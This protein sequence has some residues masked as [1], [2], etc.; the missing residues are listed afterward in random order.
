MSTRVLHEYSMNIP[1]RASGLIKQSLT[2]CAHSLQLCAQEDGFHQAKQEH[3][4]ISER[5]DYTSKQ[6]N[7]RQYTQRL[8]PGY[9]TRQARALARERSGGRCECDGI[10]S[11]DHTG[12]CL[13]VDGRQ[14]AYSRHLVRLR[15]VDGR[16]LCPGCCSRP[17][18]TPRRL[19]LGGSANVGCAQ[20]RAHE[21]TR[22]RDDCGDSRGHPQSLRARLPGPA[23]TQDTD[24]LS[25]ALRHFATAVWPSGRDDT[26]AADVCRVPERGEARP[27]RACASA[28]GAVGAFTIA[29]RRWF[30]I[31]TN[32]LRDVERPKSRPRDRL[33]S[34][35]EFAACKALAPH[36][37]RLAMQLALLTGQ[38][39]GD[40]IRFRWADI[41]EV[42]VDGRTFHE[43]QIQQSKTGKRMAIEITPE[44]EAV[45]D[46]CWQLKGGG[47]QGSEYV[48]PTKFGRPFTSAG[49][50]ATWQRVRLKW[51]RSGGENLRFHDIR[52]LAA[53]KCP[54]LEAAQQLLGHSNPAMTRRV[55]RRGIERVK[56]LRLTT[57]HA[58]AT[59]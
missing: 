58:S 18:S 42:T 19:P 51:E 25:T 37:V 16:E 52:A 46:Q 4:S 29:V 2:G 47:S 34:D 56:P 55:Y 11:R 7:T 35:E 24:G 33:I 50:R 21:H 20:M 44:L 6:A 15:L 53:T 49:F 30:W 40:I 8:A 26:R 59:I 39:Q 36:R 9:S 23:G 28:G 57:Q 22:T 41:H 38:R 10:C 31:K 54:T 17:Y 48:L 43:L 13:N 32:V 5:P 27:V 3:K 12:R 14:G 45:L 1:E